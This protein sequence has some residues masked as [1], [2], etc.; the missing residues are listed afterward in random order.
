MSYCASCGSL[1]RAGAEFCVRC[2]RRLTADEMSRAAP[3]PPRPMA[4]KAAPELSRPDVAKDVSPQT[5]SYEYDSDNWFMRHPNWTIFLGWLL[6]G[7]LALFLSLSSGPLTA[8]TRQVAGAFGAIVF[9]AVTGWGL[10][11]KGRNLAWILLSFVPF[12][13]LFILALENKRRDF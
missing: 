9:L 7:L 6:G 11:A 4:A 12:G 2:G 3:E 8:E 5:P 13:W 10:W 1:T